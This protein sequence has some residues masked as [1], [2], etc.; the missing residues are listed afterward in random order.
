[1]ANRKAQREV[2]NLFEDL[3]PY[4]SQP[5]RRDMSQRNR[6]GRGSNRNN[7]GAHGEEVQIWDEAKASF[8][9]L[10]SGI[11]SD[12]DNLGQLVAMDK[13]AGTMDSDSV[14][15]D[16]MKQMEELCRSGVK[17]SED[18]INAA[19]NLMERLKVVRA[20]VVAKEQAEAPPTGP[21]KRS[22]TRDNAAAASLYEFNGA[23]DSPVP[24]PIPSSSRKH[25]DRSSTRDSMPPKADSVE[26]PG[27][28]SGAA[29]STNKSKILFSKG[30][31]VA[32]KP[33]A[34]NGEQ[35]SDWILGEVAQ[36]LGE[37][38]SRRY[39][40]IDIEPDDQSK[41][42]EYRSSASSMIPITPESQASSLKDYEAGHVVLALYPQT[43]TFY[44]AEVHSMTSTGKVDLKFEGENDST[45]LQ[46]V[47]RRYVIEYRV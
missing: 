12:N 23:D 18:N 4:Y 8:N 38:K 44:K 42:K 2:S 6:S 14:P 1:M 21:S 5:G 16:M 31:E 20:V 11:N 10:I 32:F 17:F 7:G 9:D 35:T 36:V 25:G 24:S 22:T 3:G 43:T 28:I 33:K 37:G 19:K 46:Q 34:A 13:Q 41:Q 15:T 27:S 30:D 47:E 29:G 40:V 45:T 26:P 39:K